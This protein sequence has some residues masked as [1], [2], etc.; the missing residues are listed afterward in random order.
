[1]PWGKT[2]A[3]L[4]RGRER[5]QVTPCLPFS[6]G[7]RRGDTETPLL[8]S[9]LF[10]ASLS[11]G[12]SLNISRV[13]PEFPTCLSYPLLSISGPRITDTLA[14]VKKAPVTPDP[15]PQLS[16]LSLPLCC[17]S[18]PGLDDAL[19][20]QRKQL[21]LKPPLSCPYLKGADL[22]IWTNSTFRVSF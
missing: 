11:L 19:C 15:L 6:G 2:I 8:P 18:K 7:G 5:P 3:E 10:G 14:T 20:C 22:E 21:V 17:S 4:L 16:R 12:F 13:A 1:M 9:L